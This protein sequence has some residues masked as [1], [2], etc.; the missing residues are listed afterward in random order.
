MLRFALLARAVGQDEVELATLQVGLRHTD[1]HGVSQL[2]AGV[3]A[4]AYELEVLLVE[5]VV[6]AVE[7]SDRHKAL[8]VVLVDLAVDAIALH[9]RDM[10][11]K[12]LADKLSHKLHH[13]IFD[14][15][16]LRVLRYLL[17]VRAVL[18]QLLVVVFVGRPSSVL[19]AGEESVHH[20]VGIAAYGRREVGVVVEGQ[21]E[22]A[23]VVGGVLRLHH[24]SQ[25][26]GLHEFC[27]AVSVH[28]LHELVERARRRPL[29]ARA[30]HLVS[31]FRRQLAQ[32]FELLRIRIVMDTIGQRLPLLALAWTGHALCHSTVG[33]EHKLLDQFVGVLRPLEVAAGGFSLLIDVEMEFLRVEVDAAMAEALLSQALCQRVEHDELQ[34]VL[35][36]VA[37]LAWCGRRLSRAVHDAVVLQQ[38]LHLGVAV[39][40]VATDDG[41]DDAVVEDVGL[42]VEGEHT[43]VAE[44]LLVG[45]QRADEVAQSLGQH[46]D[47]AIDEID[48][49]GAPLRL[50]VDDV[51]L[52]DVAAHV[53]DVHTHL[54]AVALQRLD[55][56]RVVEVLGVGRVD[57]AGPGV[58]EVLAA[59]YL[60]G[61]DARLYLLRR[62][63]Y[64]LRILVGESIL[65]EDGVHLHVVVARRSEHVH[66]LS[67]E[68]LVLCV[69][70]L[71]DTHH[72]AVARL[73][74]LEPL[75]RHED[76]MDEER[77]LCDEEGN[78]AVHA[79]LAGE[80]VLL[81]MEDLRHHGLLDMVA[82]TGEELHADAVSREC[83]HGIALRDEDRRAAIVGQECVLAVGLA[84]ERA[85][86][87]LSLRVQPIRIL[88]VLGEEV[89]PCHVLH[90]V[91]GQHLHRMGGQAQILEHLLHAHGLSGSRL[92][93]VY[94]HLG[95]L[96]LVKA[97]TAFFF[98]CHSRLFCWIAA[99]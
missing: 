99:L 59:R 19:I 36:L 87:H 61:R 21:S 52:L 84:L 38:L 22:V 43:T 35:A 72:G 83:R 77:L 55:A 48:A 13:L 92:E 15:V 69:R 33:Q 74:T 96:L 95:E 26:D 49:R 31:Q 78:V 37:L 9:A 34:R 71:R 7:V 29:G 62:L 47:G 51:A 3:V 57:G 79:Q 45:P 28:L 56:Q 98:F 25:G 54:P 32:V 4:A 27:L 67:D 68:V 66:H 93:V 81:A 97:L 73:A 46:R 23:D 64:A 11:V 30:L 44:L 86:L 63:L 88:A 89:V 65:H 5:V 58:A 24:R 10:G 53:G 94:K 82:A 50:L 76:I 70:P 60:L 80:G 6:V 41:M 39:A 16:A 17:H 90:D 18:T 14:T 2:V 20:G 12:L 40:S 8:T 1:A 75:L 91:E 85:L 42:A